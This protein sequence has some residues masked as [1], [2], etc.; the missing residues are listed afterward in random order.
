MASSSH[1]FAVSRTDRP[2]SEKQDTQVRVTDPENTVCIPADSTEAVSSCAANNV[3]ELQEA[4]SSTLTKNRDLELA[5]RLS[6]MNFQDQDMR[7]SVP[8]NSSDL[9]LQAEVVQL[10]QEN[11]DLR[12]D[13]AAKDEVM[14]DLPA[15]LEN[16]QAQL[17]AIEQGFS[18]LNK[19]YHETTVDLSRVVQDIDIKLKARTAFKKLQSWPSSATAGTAAEPPQASSSASKSEKSTADTAAAPPQSSSSASR[20]E[21][22]K[23][24][25]AAGPPQSPPSAS[26]KNKAET[27]AAPSQP[28]QSAS[29]KNKADTVAG[30]PQPSSSASK[31]EKDTADTAAGPPQPSRSA[32]EPEEVATNTGSVSKASSKPDY[33]QAL[34]S[35]AEKRRILPKA[36]VPLE[37]HPVFAYQFVKRETADRT[38]SEPEKWQI[39]QNPN[40]APTRGGSTQGKDAGGHGVTKSQGN[41]TADQGET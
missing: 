31:S 20:S 19:S 22:D 3:D 10:R 12:R 36:K 11:A 21:K 1:Q 30:P 25:T 29:E 38:L 16:C 33:A 13:N 35:P 27:A 24:D 40:K 15:L 34:K 8:T 6:A 39:S 5:K 28:P 17:T 7:P 4:N 32:L 37:Q 41:P 18:A 23:T 14:S 2:V 9:A 26:K